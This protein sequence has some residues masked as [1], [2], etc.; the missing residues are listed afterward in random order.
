[1][2]AYIC[3][4]RNEV[5]FPRYYKSISLIPYAKNFIHILLIF[6]ARL[7]G[8]D[9]LAIQRYISKLKIWF[10]YFIGMFLE[11]EP[12]WFYYYGFYVIIWD[13]KYLLFALLFQRLFNY[14]FVFILLYKFLQNGTEF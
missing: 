5:L 4:S 1:M 2:Y 11:P 10:Y 7:L 13:S 9:F 14:L 6:D 8:M 3:F 12:T